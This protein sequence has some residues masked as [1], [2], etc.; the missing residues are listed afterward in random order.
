MTQ[1]P[2]L[3]PQPRGIYPCYNSRS[4]FSSDFSWESRRGRSSR[5]RSFSNGFGFSTR[6]KNAWLCVAAIVNEIALLGGKEE[7]STLTLLDHH[8]PTNGDKNRS[9]WAAKSG[10]GR[11]IRIQGSA[12]PLCLLDRSH[13]SFHSRC[14]LVLLRRERM[15]FDMD[16]GTCFFFFLFSSFIWRGVWR[17]RA[18]S[19]GTISLLRRK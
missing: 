10:G 19:R 11:S 17:I 5:S 1:V 15:N 3:D 16:S 14:N 4:N 8:L 7:R 12:P 2:G 13:P 6:R 18:P 9:G